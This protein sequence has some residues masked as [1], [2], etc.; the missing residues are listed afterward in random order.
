MARPAGAAIEALARQGSF[1]HLEAL[2]VDGVEE[3]A[4]VAVA[5]LDQG[6][7]HALGQLGG[8]LEDGLIGLQSLEHRHARGQLHEMLGAKAE[9]Q[10]VV[11]GEEEGGDRPRVLRPER[12]DAQDASLLSLIA[13]EDPAG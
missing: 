4:A 3:L 11:G 7:S 9:Q 2:V 13:H 1:H 8:L 6:R 12:T 5:H 10:R